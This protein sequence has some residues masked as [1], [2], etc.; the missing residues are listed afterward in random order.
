MFFK[1][2]SV[3][4]CFYFQ[5]KAMLAIAAMEV[6]T[7]L[8]LYGPAY[9]VLMMVGYGLMIGIFGVFMF[10]LNYMLSTLLCQFQ[11]WRVIQLVLF[12]LALVSRIAY[13]LYEYFESDKEKKA[14]DDAK[15]IK[16]ETREKRGD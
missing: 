15:K 5:L 3:G 7:N 2:P 8:F 1:V 14:K 10:A 9:V 4:E 12:W 6:L 11:A 13:I 16:E